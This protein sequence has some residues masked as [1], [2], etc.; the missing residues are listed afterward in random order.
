MREELESLAAIA[1]RKEVGNLTLAM[2]NVRES[3]GWAWLESIAAD[4]RY[5]FRALRAQ[6]TFVAA[7]VV[8]L[9]LAIG[10]N[11]AIFSL[12]DALL[13]RPLPV[14]EPSGLLDV[15]NATPDNPLEGMSFPDYR[16]LRDRSRSFAGLAAYRLGTLAAT[17]TPAAPAQLRLA[18][19]VSDNFFSV[20][21]VAP[22]LGRAFLPEEANQPGHALAMIS[23]DL[24]QQQY[25]GSS[26]AIGASLRLNGI[27]FTIIGVI[28]DSFT[29][30]DRFS[31]PTVFVP[32]GM[33]QLLGGETSNP[34]ED[35]AKHN[36]VIKGR[37]NRDISRESAMA[38]LA[39]IGAA[40]EQE[41]PNT[42]HNRRPAVRAEMDRR[43][44]Q[45]PQ[46]L[47]LI[48]MLMGMVG[49]ILVIACSNLANLLL[50]RARVRS[51]EIAIRLSIG[52][53]R[54]RLVR[55]LM[56]ESLLL[57]MI[58]GAVGLLFAYGGILLLQQLSVPSEPPSILAVQ[59]DWRIVE[60]SFLAAL[61]SCLFFGL[62]PAWQ[63]VR[64]DCLT[65]L[66][67]GGN[68]ASGPRRT[69]GRDA[70]VVG[71][72]ALAMVVLVAA[73]MFL[74][75]FRRMVTGAPDYRVDHVISMD[76]APLLVHYSPEQT[77][78]FYRRLVDLTRTISGVEAVALTESL[79]LSPSQTIVTVV[80]EGYQF[81]KG[82]EKT[83]VFGSAV[84][85][86]YFSTLRVPILR[87]RSF[88]DDD[89]AESR[90]VAVVNEQF[91][92]S[93]WPDQDPIGKR[94]RL[95]GTDGPMAEVVGVAKTGHYLVVN[96]APASYVYLPYDQNPRSRMTLIVQS[97]A[98]PSQLAGPLRETVRSIDAS[99]P[100]FNLRTV[101]TLYESRATGT[102]LQ[103]FQMVGTMGFIG[104]VLATIGLYGLVAYTVSRRV[105]E[106]GIRVALG[107]SRRDVVWLVERR[108]LLLSASGI[109]AGGVLAV[110]ASPLLSAGFLGLGTP[111]PAVW[112]VVPL[113]LLVVG[114]V[115][116]F[117]PAR[118]AAEIDPLVS[119]RNE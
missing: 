74:A 101:A 96:E 9:A 62:V 117:A 81:P 90:R 4:I 39:T 48:K 17:A 11:S 118:R 40:L 14:P 54:G 92:K 71:Q 38:E 111:S 26:A 29:G 6:P 5:A 79:P 69:L 7:A 28:P 70:L 43:I 65:A 33:S 67:A 27:L 58:G 47:S 106:F 51:R 13:L 44:Q 104:L 100:V 98:D 12:A 99:L 119:L 23:Y 25:A 46:M 53:G 91:A 107:A 103:F 94:I 109:A 112:T 77:R 73:G 97:S 80:P 30:L 66:K 84:D 59:L 68:A 19:F 95:D 34:L 8:S 45:T 85:A 82:R 10:A 50:A 108:G 35:R 56:T 3:W 22:A 93:Y 61:V 1:G 21:R 16:D 116:S 110:A 41:N 75:G 24:W 32:L 15:S 63:T 57:A 86:G 113:G 2:E 115:A 76:T 83:V 88:T 42:N 89:R 87:G 114:A 31:R 78:E 20:V 102:W 60:F 37:L 52:A 64:L 105:K 49:L 72:I 18:M 36:L 55:Q